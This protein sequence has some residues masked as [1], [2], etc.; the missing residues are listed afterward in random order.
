MTDG[1]FPA[2]AYEYMVGV[3][4]VAKKKSLRRRARTRAREVAAAHYIFEL[5]DGVSSTPH[6]DERADNRPHHVAQE[7]VGADG[8]GEHVAVLPPFGPH[9][10]AYI[11]LVVGV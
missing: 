3:A 5:C 11:G 1:L 6:I 2:S 8:K 4:H 9:D 7:A 10:M